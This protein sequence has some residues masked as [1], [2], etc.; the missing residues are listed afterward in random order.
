MK[1]ESLIKILNSV[2]KPSELYVTPDGSRVLVLPYGAR[3]LGLFPQGSDENFFWTHTA[4]ASV[5]SARA[6][7]RSA[8]W[9]NSGG[10]RTW[11]SPEID[12][13]FPDF[14]STEI[15]R[16]PP[17]LDPGSYQIER[18]GGSFRLVNRLALTLSRS[19]ETVG[20]VITKSWG[21][22]PNPLRHEHALRELAGAE[23]AGYTQSTTLQLV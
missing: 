2:G 5:G 17:Q 7:Y 22:A 16:Q 8:Q 18:L 4:L 11:I 14:P 20:L 12:V 15:Y 1:C 3:V 13:F 10:D 19:R 23:Y 6:F 21:P 9:H